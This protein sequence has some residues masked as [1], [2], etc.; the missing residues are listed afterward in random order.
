VAC[1]LWSV[2][3]VCGG[4]AS[5]SAEFAAIMATFLHTERHTPQELDS[6]A[7]SSPSPKFPRTP[8]LAVFRQLYMLGVGPGGTSFGGIWHLRGP[9][10]ESGSGIWHHVMACLCS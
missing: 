5:L 10:P 1:G 9:G 4:G 2:S 3:V 7:S 8:Q 6:P